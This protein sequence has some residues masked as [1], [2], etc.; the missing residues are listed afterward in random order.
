[1]N[2]ALLENRVS[3]KMTGKYAKATSGFE[4]EHKERQLVGNGESK[5]YKS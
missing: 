4:G 3:I 1:M 5:K 2:K